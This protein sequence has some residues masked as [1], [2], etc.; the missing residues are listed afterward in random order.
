MLHP[1]TLPLN[2]LIPILLRDDGRMDIDIG[3]IMLIQISLPKD[4][5]PEELKFSPET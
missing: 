2:T 1:V 5:D 3:G 4:P